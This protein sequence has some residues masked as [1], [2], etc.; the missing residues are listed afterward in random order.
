MPSSPL[1]LKARGLFSASASWARS[2]AHA[3]SGGELQP[4]RA[5][6]PVLAETAAL[7]EDGSASAM[8]LAGLV[9]NNESAEVETAAVA[10]PLPQTAVV[11]ATQAPV[12]AGNSAAP[13]QPAAS[14]DSRPASDSIACSVCTLRDPACCSVCQMH[15]GRMHEACRMQ[16]PC[17]HDVHSGIVGI[18]M[19]CLLSSPGCLPMCRSAA[20][21]HPAL[22]VRLLAWPTSIG[23]SAIGMHMVLPS[24]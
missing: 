14:A 18:Q 6:P 8:H 4:V 24:S 13:A 12:S 21:E 20:E 3:G 19:C 5:L 15:R 2:V 17:D 22:F 7:A 1:H 16:R 11:P 9:I 10:H 23:P